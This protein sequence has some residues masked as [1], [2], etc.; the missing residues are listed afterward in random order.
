MLILRPSIQ[1]SL[2]LY[3]SEY[4]MNQTVNCAAWEGET[5]SSPS[6]SCMKRR[7]PFPV[8]VSLLTETSAADNGDHRAGEY[9]EEWRENLAPWFLRRKV[10]HI[11][12]THVPTVVCIGIVVDGVISLKAFVGY[13]NV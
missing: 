5:S 1:L 3:I 11:N 12:Q 13:T 10:L 8:P 4:E 2:T 6:I 7:R 9:E